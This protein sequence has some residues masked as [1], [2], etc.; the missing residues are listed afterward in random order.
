MKNSS[1]IME[2]KAR[3]LMKIRRK[4]KKEWIKLLKC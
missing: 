4:S 2:E 1:R 3:I